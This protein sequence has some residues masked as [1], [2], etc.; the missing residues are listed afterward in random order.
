M[1]R[2]EYFDLLVKSASDGTF[3]SV[4]DTLSC[5]YR[6]NSNASCPQRC[7]I[8]VLIPDEKYHPNMERMKCSFL[9]ERFPFMK[10]FMPDGLTLNDLKGIQSGHDRCALTG[11]SA[12]EFVKSI[13][14]LSC[15]SDMEAA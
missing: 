12:E 1:T 5:M 11:W 4:S 15:F 14:R 10:T 7:A 2:K 3:P 9:F 6:G 8:G 13:R